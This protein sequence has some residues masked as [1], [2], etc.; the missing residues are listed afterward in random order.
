[1]VTAV[2]RML[3]PNLARALAKGTVMSCL[4]LFFNQCVTPCIDDK[5]I[6]FKLLQRYIFHKSLSGFKR[7]INIPHLHVTMTI[8]FILHS[9]CNVADKEFGNL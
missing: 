3:P 5:P 4:F 9:I 2:K 1:M 6:E 8:H 7:P